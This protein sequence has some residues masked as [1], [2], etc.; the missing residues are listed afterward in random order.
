MEA[1]IHVHDDAVGEDQPAGGVIVVLAQLPE[2]GSPQL[3]LLPGGRVEADD[4]EL[5][6]ASRAQTI[7]E[8]DELALVADVGL[9][10][11]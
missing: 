5:Q 8:V 10:H 7:N 9:A 1:P 4:G 2:P 11:G 6:Q 3:V